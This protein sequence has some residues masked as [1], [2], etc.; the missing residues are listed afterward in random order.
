MQITHRKYLL[1][2]YRAYN[3]EIVDHFYT[4]N[5]QEFAETLNNL[6]YANDGNDGY[7]AQSAS[8]CSCGLPLYRM[9]NE[10][11]YDH[12]Y[13]RKQTTQSARVLFFPAAF[14]FYR[15]QANS[16]AILQSRRSATRM[17]ALQAI[18]RR[19]QAVVERKHFFVHKIFFVF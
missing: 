6:K 3:V 7:I 8:S 18:A 9:Y 16:N 17:K 1:R 13:V 2:W 4:P 5:Q 10:Q 14:S 12:F 11:R 19:F 15:Q